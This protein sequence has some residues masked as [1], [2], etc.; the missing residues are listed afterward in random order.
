MFLVHWKQD[1]SKNCFSSF[2]YKMCKE[3]HFYITVLFKWKKI[4]T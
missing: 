4:L 1:Y 2:F 3:L